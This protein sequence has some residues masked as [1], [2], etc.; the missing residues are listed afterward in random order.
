[1]LQDVYS[2][3]SR[4][5]PDLVYIILSKITLPDHGVQAQSNSFSGARKL[6]VPDFPN[7]CGMMMSWACSARLRPVLRISHQT[8]MGM[9]GHKTKLSTHFRV[10]TLNIIIP[11]LIRKTSSAGQNQSRQAGGGLRYHMSRVS[12]CGLTNIRLTRTERRVPG[13]LHV[14][15]GDCT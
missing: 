12:A 11:G 3:F 10:N 4:K 5:R 2:A 8:L 14:A 1:M 9:R 7:H 6:S 13:T 15:H